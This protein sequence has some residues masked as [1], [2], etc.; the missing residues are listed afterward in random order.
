[1]RRLRFVGY[2]LLLAVAVGVTAGV[3]AVRNQATIAKI[4]LGRIRDHTGFDIQIS[5]TRV[6]FN[7]RLE[8]VLEH[9]RV[10]RAGVEVARLKE[11]RA[12]LGYR[13]VFRNA[14]LPVY[15]LGFE[16]PLARVPA[17]GANFAADGFAHLDAP[18][19]KALSETL[20]ALSDTVQHIKVNEATLTDEHNVPIV[21]HLNLEASRWHYRHPGN[22]PWQV[23]FT[24]MPAWVP[25]DPFHLAGRVTLGPPLDHPQLIANGEIWFWDLRVTGVDVG[26]AKAAAKVDGNLHVAL[27]DTGVLSGK[28]NTNVRGLSLSGG[29]LSKPLT[30]GDYQI[31]AGYHAAPDEI[32]LPSVTLR[33]EGVIVL[34]GNARIV[35]PY[36]DDRAATFSAGGTRLTLARV[37]SLMRSV[38]A[39]PPSLLQFA[40]RLDQG[41]IALTQIALDTAVPLRDWSVATL[42]NNLRAAAILTNV[43]YQFPPDSK[44]MPLRDF[45]GQLAYAAGL[46]TL[47][48]GSLA[49]G[50]SR[51]DGLSADV[52]LSRA[53]ALISYKT[54]LR[55]DLDLG[56]LYPA[57]NAVAR[58]ASPTIADN[59]THVAG[60]AP[61]VLSGSGDSKD[62]RWRAPRDY[63]ATFDLSRAVLGTRSVPEDIVFA[64]GSA[65]LSPAGISLDHVRLLPAG[66]K[67]G[68]IVLNGTLAPR[69][70]MPLLHN[71]TA[72][73]HQLVIEQWLPRFVDPADLAADG[74]VSGAL[75]ANSAPGHED[76]PVITGKLTLTAGQIQFGFVRS[77]MIVSRAA[78]LILDGK[79]LTLD[80]PGAKL[81]GSALDFRLAVADLAHP[82]VRLDATAAKLDFEVLRFIRL[83]WSPRTP[84]HFFPVP[85]SGHI[86]GR[87]ANFGE[88]P[89]SNVATDFTKAGNDWHVSNFTATVLKGDVHL[90]IAGRSRDDW[91]RIIGTIAGMDARLLSTLA[92]PGPRPILI[93]TLAANGDIWAHTDVDFFD[94]LGGT[95][96]VRVTDGL[97]NRF[98]L[99]TR[100]LGL[101]DL[102]SWLTAQVDPLVTGVPFKA[103]TADFLG[104]G[105]D[106]KTKNL[107]L[108][109]PVVDIT[110]H[111]DVQFGR[112]RVNMEVGVF[113]FNT[114]NWI[115]HQIPIVG[116]NLAGGTKGLVAA[117]FAVYGPLKDP[118]VLPKPVTSVAEFVKKMLGL[119]INI[120]V[121]NTIK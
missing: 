28:S 23:K 40:T 78:T 58:T 111:G 73:L 115:V 11:I 65:V 74:T 109:G 100:I 112:E 59:V 26:A 25:A 61:V 116:G 50:K 102:K 5:G 82:A 46:L 35:H 7:R 113:P 2:A 96:S 52:N 83:P 86:E 110:A 77:P 31:S 18:A 62:L 37:S 38:R 66:A 39:I 13:A 55:G 1:M 34:S 81:E 6:A 91:I 53:P 104:A 4:V 67:G 68:D 45:N 15:E 64:Q 95:L 107:L 51:F 105:G 75:T 56:E 87:E 93:G 79:G 41:E 12:V 80:L 90:D 101:I 33:Q 114:A 22:W 29:S 118:T 89:L 72:Q 76:F 69:P 106:F 24:A 20:D 108:D 19:I 47:T 119:P 9:P 42:R 21:E 27:D 99:L 30:P 121:P 120:I 48:Q 32:D 44:L 36:T 70:G 14:G 43:G 8:V 16:Q 88:L 84:P 85:V 71:F 63:L 117:Y 92:A 103:L 98:K 60:R 57:A 17:G 10:L 49:I 3:V 54:K 94:S 97:V